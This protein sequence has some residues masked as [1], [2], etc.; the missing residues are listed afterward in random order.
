MPIPQRPW[1]SDFIR[2]VV[3]RLAQCTM[4]GSRFPFFATLALLLVWCI[5]SLWAY[6]PSD[7]TIGGIIY[8]FAL[9][10]A[11]LFFGKNKI[12]SLSV[13]AYSLFVVLYLPVAQ[14]WGRVDANII[15]SLFGTN[16]SES[17][18]FLSIIPPKFYALQ[19]LFAA[20]VMCL[21]AMA[22]KVACL[23]T[24]ECDWYTFVKTCVFIYIYIYIYM[25]VLEW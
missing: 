4:Q 19:L 7:V 1:L 5:T 13:I 16:M 20:Q 3:Q 18:E 23:R 12:F 17:K 8:M 25:E 10:A 21:L 24:G 22:K 9:F 15:S 14:I 6:S 11:I 2:F